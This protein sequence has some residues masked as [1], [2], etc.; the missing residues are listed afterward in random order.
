M[1]PESKLR[2]A[3]RAYILHKRLEGHEEEQPLYKSISSEDFLYSIASANE[4]SNEY[5]ISISPFGGFISRDT[6]IEELK[7][8]LEVLDEDSHK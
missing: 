1:I 7:P 6:F 4:V 3:I 8:F 5:T 2:T